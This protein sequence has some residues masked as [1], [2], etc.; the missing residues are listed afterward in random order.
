MHRTGF[1]MRLKPGSEALYKEKHDQIW[2]GLLEVLKSQGV[3]RYAIYRFQ[4]SL[5]CNRRTSSRGD[6]EL[7]HRVA[8][9]FAGK[10]DEAT[11]CCRP[12]YCECPV[13]SRGDLPDLATGGGAGS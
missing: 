8:E 3:F 4:R 6:V 1:K 9:T 11:S 5:D 10:V 13:E 7:D 12:W 2:P